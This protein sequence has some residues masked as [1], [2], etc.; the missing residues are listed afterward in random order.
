M[1]LH[2]CPESMH[3]DEQQ[4]CFARV[5]NTCVN[6]LG[7]VRTPPLALANGMWISDVPLPLN[8]LSLPEHVLVARFFPA[9]YIVK[10]YPK[11]KGART[12][13]LASSLHSGLRGNVSTT[14]SAQIKSQVWFVTTYCCHLLLFLLQQ[15]ESPSWG[16]KM[17]RRR[18]CQ[19]SFR[20]IGHVSAMPSVG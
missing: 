13:A 16:Q 6:I 20:S 15:L 4:T 2:T 7:Q 14:V 3:C 8:I 9:A 10:L 18:R 19:A 17:Y 12:W 11:K 5:C 1:L